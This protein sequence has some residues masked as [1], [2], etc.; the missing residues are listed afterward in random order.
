[1]VL[2]VAFSQT[3]AVHGTALL[4]A[5]TAAAALHDHHN[6]FHE[7]NTDDQ[8]A[9]LHDGD[10][11]HDKPNR[12][13]A[14]ESAMDVRSPDKAENPQFRLASVDVPPPGRPPNA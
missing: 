8:H 11:S 2:M 5:D 6:H 13:V 10:H 7:S 4:P 9:Q 12:V 3:V 1:M 14:S